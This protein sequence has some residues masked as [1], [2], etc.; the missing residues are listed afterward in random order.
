MR[1]KVVL[2]VLVVLFLSMVAGC[3]KPLLTVPSFSGESCCANIPGISLLQNEVVDPGSMST[4]VKAV[5]PA[6]KKAEK[7]VEKKKNALEKRRAEQEAKPV[8]DRYKI[9]CKCKPGDWVRVETKT[10]VIEAEFKKCM[11]F[12]IRVKPKGQRLGVILFEQIWMVKKIVPPPP[13]TEPAKPVVPQ[14]PMEVPGP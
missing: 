1:F 14:A 4:V 3:T 11:Y 5:E 9:F 2:V 7:K 10:R 13:K 8:P 12:G 6:G